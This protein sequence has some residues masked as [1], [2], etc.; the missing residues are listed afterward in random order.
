MLSTVYPNYGIMCKPGQSITSGKRLLWLKMLF[1]ILNHLDTSRHAAI[2][3]R[4]IGGEIVCLLFQVPV[5]RVT[6]YPLL[7]N[8]LHKVTPC[9]NEDRNAIKKAQEKIE[10]ALEQMNKV[11]VFWRQSDCAI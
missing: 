4:V 7:L 11:M 5:Q 10:S 8:R 2:S 3:I 9:H 6:K 1:P